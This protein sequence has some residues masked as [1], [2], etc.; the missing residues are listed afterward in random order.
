M[1]QVPPP[2][3]RSSV[4]AGEI[5]LA[6]SLRDQFIGLEAKPGSMRVLRRDGAA[7]YNGSPS[8]DTPRTP[9]PTF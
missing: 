9:F 1:S 3:S 5:G 4:K 8:F 6:E 7:A 2:L